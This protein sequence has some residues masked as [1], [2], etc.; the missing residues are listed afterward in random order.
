[1]TRNTVVRCGAPNR[2]N[3]NHNGAL[4][5]W[6]IDGPMTSLVNISDIEITDSSF[7]GIT[8]WGTSQLT[9]TYFNNI[10]ITT[11]PYAMEVNSVNGQAY[12]TNV[13][14]SDLS[15]GGIYSCDAGF[16]LVQVSGNS[17]WSDSH[18]G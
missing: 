10:K 1:M 3:S 5:F 2:Y 12:F 14:A 18:C 15:K 8:F 7:A 17:G 16:K 9:A 6:P 11:A 4:W 13:V